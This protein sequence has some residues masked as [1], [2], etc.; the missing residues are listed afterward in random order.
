MLS[1]T[2]RQVEFALAVAHHGGMS[3]AAQ[4]LH[5]SQPALS[6]AIGQ[7]EARLGEA[8]FLRRPG[9]RLQPSPFGHRWLIEAEAG[10][11]QMRRLAD[12]AALKSYPL[13]LAVFQDLAASCL[14]PLLAMATTEAPA[15][16]LDTR[17]M[18]FEALLSAL[19]DGTVDLALT[20]DLGLETDIDRRLVTRIPPHAVLAAAHP[21]AARP[22]LCLRD[23]ADEPLILTDQGLSVGHMRG[24][25][26]SAGL[27]PRIAHRT[28]SL[29]LMR[30]FAANGFGVGLS[31]TNPAPRLSQDGKPLVTRPILD[32]GTEALVLARLASA[33][34]PPGEEAL[35]GLLPKTLAACGFSDTLT[36]V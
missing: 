13:R 4:A 2:L 19:R 22:G 5:I 23:L 12:P 21:L 1:L 25:F 34:V 20:W 33:T 9:G 26:S 28:A 7:L 24:L 35:V 18:G 14:A 36:P 17:P 11:G 6:V 29:D 3:A 10:L 15:L 31:Y 16:R 32:A 30:S 8:L 27:A